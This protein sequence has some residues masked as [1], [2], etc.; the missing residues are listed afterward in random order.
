VRSW[1]DDDDSQQWFHDRSD[2]VGRL[3]FA[4]VLAYLI[5]AVVV[6]KRLLLR[7]HGLSGRGGSEVGAFV[8]GMTS[9]ANSSAR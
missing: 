1:L 4:V 8:A 2:A 6:A 9:S 7:R 5:T 3:V